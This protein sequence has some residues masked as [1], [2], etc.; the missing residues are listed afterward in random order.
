MPE[1]RDLKGE[2]AG[3]WPHGIPWLQRSPPHCFLM[4]LL[5]RLSL[6]LLPV[7]LLPLPAQIM[8]E[9][10][11]SCLL[12]LSSNEIQQGYDY[13]K[14]KIGFSIEGHVKVSQPLTGQPEFLS[15]DASLH[16][17]EVC[18]LAA[19]AFAAAS[20]AASRA[21]AAASAFLAACAFSSASLSAASLAAASC[22]SRFAA[23]LRAFSRAF[24]WECKRA[25][26][27]YLPAHAAT[28]Q[29]K[30]QHLTWAHMAV[31]STETTQTI[32]ADDSQTHC[33]YSR[34]MLH[35]LSMTAELAHLNDQDSAGPATLWQSGHFSTK[36]AGPLTLCLPDWGWSHLAALLARALLLQQLH[37]RLLRLLRERLLLLFRQPGCHELLFLCKSTRQ[38]DQASHRYNI[39]Q[40]ART[41]IICERLL[42]LIRQPRRPQ[43]LLLC[44]CNCRLGRA[45]YRQDIPQVPRTE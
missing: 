18:T 11:H 44:K 20:R 42:L 40:A 36:R 34:R 31:H 41:D 4:P 45:K 39:P 13:Q 32:S 23:F 21:A 22:C 24:S 15:A 3:L 8:I 5:S 25:G 12:H 7:P 19:A 2:T 6:L 17:C 26:S 35:M 27:R 29:V 16:N 33:G 37:L 14:S 30:Q 43:L 28:Q 10:V 9:P 1:R 38:S